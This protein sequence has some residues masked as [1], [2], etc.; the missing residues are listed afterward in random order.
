MHP[1]E[2]TF[3]CILSYT[4]L[5]PNFKQLL[6]KKNQIETL[7]ATENKFYEFHLINIVFFCKPSKQSI[8]LHFL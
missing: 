5:S 8:H 1:V 3:S 6:Q 4:F 2:D 7:H